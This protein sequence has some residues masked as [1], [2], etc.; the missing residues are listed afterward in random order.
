[1]FKLFRF[2][3]Y[4]YLVAFVF[5]LYEA[6][7][8]WGTEG[9]RGYLYIFFAAIALFMFFFK[10]NFREKMTAKGNNQ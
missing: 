4:V 5:F 9:K 6:Y 10:R 7:A 8:V 3:E 1:M 2:I